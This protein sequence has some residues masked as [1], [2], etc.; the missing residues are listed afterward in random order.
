MTNHVYAVTE[1]IGS[2]PSSLEEAIRNATST[3]AK[4]LHNLEWFEV[5]EMRGHLNTDGSVA[6]FQVGL[7]LGFRYERK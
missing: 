7:K 5:T 3:A 6:H 1:V 2:S 4:T